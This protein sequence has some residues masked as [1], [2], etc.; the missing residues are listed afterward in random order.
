MSKPLAFVSVDVE[1]DGPCPGL[2][3]M[4]SL[5]AVLITPKLDQTFYAQFAPISRNWDVKALSVSGHTRNQCLD[6]PLARLGMQQFR[7]WLSQFDAQPRFVSENNGFDW[8][9]VNY[10]FWTYC[11][12]NPFG[13][14][15]INLSSLYKGVKR[16]F[17]ESINRL[18]ITKHTHHPV[19]DAMGN[20][21]VFLK[22]LQSP[23]NLKI[24][25][26]YTGQ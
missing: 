12:E 21:E 9:F 7:K 25:N 26:L 14:S 17:S 1:A 3:S 2:Y 5:G 16:N 10:Y 4:V 24:K 11:A 23:Y 13:S 22:L 8:Q 18:R 19:D 20:A 6:F 15:S